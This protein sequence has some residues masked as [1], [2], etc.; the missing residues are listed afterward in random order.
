M[1][2]ASLTQLW[3]ENQSEAFIFTFLKTRA[4]FR[5]ETDVSH[6]EHS[7]W[8]T[9]YIVQNEQRGFNVSA[10]VANLITV[11]DSIRN[12]AKKRIKF[13]KLFK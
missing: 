8:N 13:Y 7:L 9:F 12:F 2:I 5:E 3:G 1:A 11:V 6:T 10:I 4:H